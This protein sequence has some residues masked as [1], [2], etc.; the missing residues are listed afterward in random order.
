VFVSAGTTGLS[1][2]EQARAGIASALLNT[3]HEV[4]GA[5]TVGLLT[6]FAGGD[7]G[8]GLVGLAAMGLLGA[9]IMIALMPPVRLAPGAP[10]FTH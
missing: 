4:G 5:A 8:A 7:L 6:A 2:V 10:T 1:D 9:I 3:A